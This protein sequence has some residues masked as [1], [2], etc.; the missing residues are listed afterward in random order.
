MKQFVLL[1]AR[2]CLVLLAVTASVYAD[3]ED[4]LVAYWSFEGGE[5][6]D[7]T[8]NGNNGL[9]FGS[10]S[11]VPGVS[12]DALFFNGV[13]DYADCGNTSSINITGDQLSLCAWIRMPDPHTN[14]YG[15]IISKGPVWTPMDV[16][17]YF[18]YTLRTY[19]ETNQVGGVTNSSSNNVVQVYSAVSTDTWHFLTMVYD[20]VNQHLYINGQE[21]ATEPQSGTIK[22]SPRI[23]GQHLTV[24]AVESEGSYQGYFFHGAIDEARIY[25]RALAPEEV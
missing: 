17:D 18:S 20:G 4:G 25:D 7:H 21:V 22:S 3:L 5:V 6:T 2:V 10:P 9:I 8:G 23:D 13:N 12:G 24:G 1:V 16:S 11:T 14:D 19:E 15:A